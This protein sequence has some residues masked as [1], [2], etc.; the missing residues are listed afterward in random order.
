M[1]FTINRALFFLSLQRT[2][3]I[4][5][6][7]PTLPIIENLLITIQNK[8]MVIV[9]TNLELEITSVVPI[10]SETERYSFVVSG[11]KLL[12]ICKFFPKDATINIILKIK[13]NRIILNYK[14]SYFKLC[15]MSDKDFPIFNKFKDKIN[16]NIT[17]Q[18]FLHLIESTMFSM[19]CNDV[20]FY[21]NGM[22][23]LYDKHTFNSVS[24][25]GHRIAISSSKCYLNI[26]N[27]S[28]ILSRRTVLEIVKIVKD[29]SSLITFKIGK[30]SILMETNKV[31]LK[32]K[33]ING[34]FPSYSSL[35]SKDCKSIV[36]IDVKAL[37]ETLL[38]A[39]VLSEHQFNGVQF[40][41]SKD[42][43]IISSKNSSE[44]ISKELLHINYFG[45][46]ISFF[47]NVKYVLDVLNVI[48]EKKILL[49]LENPISSIQF[50]GKKNSNLVYVIMPLML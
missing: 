50:R 2:V 29:R 25:D 6:R 12:E 27:F 26:P 4:I 17:G 37:K 38:R 46:S 48:N 45:K 43:L 11:K 42:K 21:L 7:N 31:V 1:K 5:V 35:L 39:S 34:D 23:F 36:E 47:I 44:E 40:S 3:S 41:I 10:S 22:L 15:I 18:F 14:N 28:I 49:F 20:R 30:N 9:S 33:L 16:F 19:A 8:L 13:D 24:T 32:A